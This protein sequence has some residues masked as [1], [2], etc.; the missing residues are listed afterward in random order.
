[1][2]GKIGL[3]SRFTPVVISLNNSP[4]V[5]SPIPNGVIFGEMNTPGNP[6]VASNLSPPVASVPGT[7]GAEKRL[8]S[9]L[10]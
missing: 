2:I 4:S 6:I 5:H 10:A 3:P 8:K 1:M 7:G 9:L